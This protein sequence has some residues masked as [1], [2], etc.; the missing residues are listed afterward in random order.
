M[1]RIVSAEEVFAEVDKDAIFYERSGGGVTLSG[2][3]PLAQSEFAINILKLCKDAGIP[4]AIETCGHA[5]W[6]KVEGV[7]KYVDL[8]LYDI[9]H[10]DPAAHKKV[11][12]VS[13][14]L[15]L[16]N[17]KRIYHEAHIPLIIR[18]P[19]IPAFNDTLETMERTAAFILKEL[20]SSVPVHLLPYHRLGESK[21][22]QME[23]SQP[24]LGI[25]PPSEE[26]LEKLK[27]HLERAGLKVAI[28]G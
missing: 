15:I 26:Y 14:I 20:D 23:R 25:E 10:M 16:E 24:S 9:K 17:L 6:E 11:T 13:N 19:V 5:P 28:G 18:I 2:G 12:E 27:R 22:E 3:E 4:T 21:W 1:G 8:V 7:L